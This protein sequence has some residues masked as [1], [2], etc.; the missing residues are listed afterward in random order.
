M[1]NRSLCTYRQ[2]AGIGTTS[3]GTRSYPE[4]KPART[5]LADSPRRGGRTRRRR[6]SQPASQPG[7]AEMDVPKENDILLLADEKFDFDLSLSSSSANEDDEVF[8]GPLGHKERC[9]AASLELNHH[10]PEEPLVPASESHFI[11]SP[12]PGEK[13]VEVYK[14]AHLLA[15]QIES[16]SKNKAAQDVTAE[17][18]WSQGVERFIQESKL[19]ISLFE[20]EN[21]MKKSPKSL[22]RETYYLSDSPLRDPPLQGTQTPS[23]MVLPSAPAQTQGRPHSPHSS[24]PVEPSTAHP[25]NQAGTQKKVIS[26]LVR[27]RAFSVRGKNIHVAAEQNPELIRAQSL[28]A[29]LKPEQE[30]RKRI[31]ASPSNMKILNEKESHRDVPPDKSSATRELASLPAGGSHLVQGKRSLPVPNKLGLKKTL[32]KLPGCA[33]G[34]SRKF[35]SSGS[36]SAVISR[37]CASPAA[38]R[39]EPPDSATP[40]SC[41]AQRPQSCTSAGRVVVHNTPAR[42]SSVAAP[43]SLVSSTRTPTSTK[44]VSALPTPASR[45]LSGLPFMT[46][47]TVPRALA[48]PLC[49]PARWRSSEPQKKS[50]VRAAPT[51]ETHSKATSR[52]EDSSPDGSL[53]PL[54]A[55]PQALNFSPEK[56]GLTLSGSISTEVVLD[57]A[58]PPGDTPTSEAILVDIKLDQ[59]AITPKAESTALIDIP[60]IDFCN[61]PEGHVVLGSES[62]P[63]IDL[64]INTPDMNRNTASKPPQEVGQLIDLASP[65]IQLS[66]EADK[67]NMDSPLLKF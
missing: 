18:L 44:H 63:L 26:K 53:S 57:A 64:L 52:R 59:L 49:V 2:K 56:T 41:R 15:L 14:E 25:P 23:G 19:K 43:Q 5:Q 35:S 33:G 55:V 3:L 16:K 13:F 29:T 32:L 67:E 51:R 1:R 42:H 36:V 6:A 60:L 39:G 22:K 45:R 34:L 21:E 61:S 8:F 66:P 58:Q 48:S 10:I 54:S 37:A 17:D 62:R 27:P 40:K 65:L 4:A 50:S 24:L 20:K 46:P 28:S 30:P 11:W 38:G 12:L 9:V 47:K 31:P 7:E